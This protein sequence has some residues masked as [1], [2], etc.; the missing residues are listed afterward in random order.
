[1]RQVWLVSIL[2][3]LGT[4][5]GAVMT[6]RALTVQPNPVALS[7]EVQSHLAALPFRALVPTYLP[8]GSEPPVVQI[9]A[10]A[11]GAVRGLLA[12]RTPR[13]CFGLQETLA[14]PPPPTGTDAVLV[15]NPSFGPATVVSQPELGSSALGNAQTARAVLVAPSRLGS[16]G[17]SPPLEAGEAR[18]VVESLR[19]VP[20]PPPP[21][22]A[23]Q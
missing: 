11:R 17:C 1:M 12:Y 14:P 19:A 13:G 4:V 18:K 2:F 15:E 3:G 9:E 10:D 21:L 16:V 8:E 23:L 7:E 22:P 6:W 20:G 5:A